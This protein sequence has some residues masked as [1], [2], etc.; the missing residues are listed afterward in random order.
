MSLL[1]VNYVDIKIYY[2]VHKKGK[3]KRIEVIFKEKAEEM[4]KDPEKGKDIEVLETKWASSLTWKEEK[5]I[6][7]KAIEFDPITQKNTI[8]TVEYRDGVIKSCLKDWNLVDDE[9]KKIPLINKNIDSLP[10]DIVFVLYSEYDEIIN[11]S[12]EEAKN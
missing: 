2:R 8:N 4:I 1:D 3:A 11:Y 6:S 5:E 7:K 12:E 9:G 10:S